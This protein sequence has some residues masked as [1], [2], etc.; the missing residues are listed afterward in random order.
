M[1]KMIDFAH[2]HRKLGQRDEGYLF[3]LSNLIWVLESLSSLDIGAVGLNSGMHRTGTMKS[4]E[5]FEALG[6]ASDDDPNPGMYRTGTMKSS[7]FF[8]ALGEAS[9]DDLEPG[10]YRTG[11]IYLSM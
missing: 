8:D 5:F 4:S 1:G 2:V 9:D 7:E 3:G 6:A 10:M 11:T